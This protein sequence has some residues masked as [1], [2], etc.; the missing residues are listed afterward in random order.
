MGQMA[1]RIREIYRGEQAPEDL[2]SQITYGATLLV[3]EA[4]GQG[5]R[6]LH[7]LQVAT[8]LVLLLA[9]Y[10]AAA[11]LLARSL[12]RRNEMAVRSA[13]GAQPA[14]LRRLLLAEGALLGLLGAAGGILLAYAGLGPSGR[15]LAWSYPDLAIE[16]LAMDLP[17]VLMAA[18]LG[19]VLGAG[20]ALAA[21]PGQRLANILRAGG[22]NR[23][24]A[25]GRSRRLLVGAQ[26]VLGGALLLG[27]L[28][29]QNGLGRLMHAD[30]GFDPNQVWCFQIQPGKRIPMEARTQLAKSITDRLAALPGI[31]AAGAGNG[32]P[33]S[34]FRSDLYTRLAD[35]RKIDPEARAMTPGT[36]RALGLR[37]LR[38][39]DLQ[40]TD[41]ADSEKVM[42]V[43]RRLAQEAFGTDDVVGRSLTFQEQTF[44][45]VGVLADVREFSPA[46]EPPPIFYLP[47][48]QAGI[49]WNEDLYVAFRAAGPPPSEPQ[50]QALLREAA[51]GQALHRYRPMGEL[52]KTQLG[53]QRMARAFM[54]AFAA[55]ALLLAA[56][57]VFGLMTASVAA[58][59]AEFGV[60]SALGAS[61]LSLLGQVLREALQ[62][63]ALAGL[64]GVL[65]GGA[66][67]RLCRSVLGAWPDPPLLLA[68]LA[69]G[70]LVGAALAATF[71]PALR[72]AFAPPSTAL[73]E[74]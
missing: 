21:Q 47:L 58:R 38:G 44:T 59:R 11:L 5:L 7:I 40:A 56:G 4:L 1:E 18:L 73:R 74:E 12:G 32:L 69:L 26:L 19:P 41:T 52:L 42:L 71:L 64:A 63:A 14:D 72:A 37:L 17:S 24:L 51:P 55:L 50:M 53:P 33:M 68:F 30:P 60:R 2:L 43:T 28:S 57:G 35:G 49:V 36:V 66:L 23:N 15:V 6:V 45:I 39:R 65:L 3:D 20:C 34:G 13:L 8:G 48:P 62:L 27:A 61:P 70:A 22:R 25:T 16:G 67:E 31:Q 46:Q 9:A 29:L 54:A 10:N